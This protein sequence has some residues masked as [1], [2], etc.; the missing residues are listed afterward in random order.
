MAMNELYPDCDLLE[1]YDDCTECYRHDI[2]DAT[3]LLPKLRQHKIVSE[4]CSFKFEMYNKDSINHLSNE[5]DLKIHFR[6]TELI[7]YLISL[8]NNIS[9]YMRDMHT[10]DYALFL[11]PIENLSH[12]Y[13]QSDEDYL[14]IVYYYQNIVNLTKNH[15]SDNTRLKARF[16]AKNIF[17]TLVSEYE[18][19]KV[20]DYG[21]E[22]A[23]ACFRTIVAED[24]DD[25]MKKIQKD[26]DNI[27][28]CVNLLHPEKGSEPTPY[29]PAI[30]SPG[31]TPFGIMDEESVSF[32][33][34][35]EKEAGDKS[36][37]SENCHIMDY[38]DAY[39][40]G[41]RGMSDDLRELLH[42]GKG[43]TKEE[44]KKCVNG[45]YGIKAPEIDTDVMSER[46]ICSIPKHIMK[47]TPLKNREVVKK[48]PSPDKPEPVVFMINEH[49]K[50]GERLVKE[51][52]QWGVY[53]IDKEPD[54]MDTD[55]AAFHRDLL[56]DG[57]K[58]LDFFYLK[59]RE[60]TDECVAFPKI[61]INNIPKNMILYKTIKDVS[62]NYERI[63]RLS[64]LELI[65]DKL[66]C[67][68][69]VNNLS[70]INIDIIFNIP[71]TTLYNLKDDANVYDRLLLY[72]YYLALR[73]KD[74]Y[75]DAYAYK[76]CK[77][78]FDILVDYHKDMNFA[79][80]SRVF[81]LNSLYMMAVDMVFKKYELLIAKI[82][83]NQL[84]LRDGE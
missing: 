38:I 64:I 29:E 49:M 24:M 31:P 37:K 81:T 53:S 39:V 40:Y 6:N 54:Y 27:I 14:T 7:R 12:N 35:T 72:Y 74:R 3:S 59:D 48:E 84:K 76:V 43:I 47:I 15:I 60:N 17:K 9:D 2:C 33:P 23:K 68:D 57:T 26:K 28:Y 36:N 52:G 10:W 46:L 8:R 78:I 32:V 66:S 20:P 25:A 4:T 73:Y 82:K 21:N 83:L 22:N 63:N 55:I 41:I 18:L 34:Y 30:I 70:Y 62:S 44:F 80:Y 50:P 5:N 79:Q 13:T 56:D 58:R 16:I 51:N 61:D 71:F 75:P 45:I 42:S 19:F 11:G 1:K 77:D 67:D 69:I 65:Y